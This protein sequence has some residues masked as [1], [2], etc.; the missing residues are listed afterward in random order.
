MTTNSALSFSPAPT[1]NFRRS[2]EGRTAL[3]GQ[4]PGPGAE[5]LRSLPTSGRDSSP[6]PAAPNCHRGSEP[7]RRP[8]LRRGVPRRLEMAPLRAALGERDEPPAA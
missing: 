7:R 4:E 3:G 6:R 1:F 8:G 2:L 5:S